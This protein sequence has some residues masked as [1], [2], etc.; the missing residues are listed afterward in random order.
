M[1]EVSDQPCDL[2]DRR[3]LGQVASR[4]QDHH[5]FVSVRNP[6]QGNDVEHRAPPGE[7]RCLQSQA[8]ARFLTVSKD[9]HEPGVSVC[10]VHLCGQQARSSIRLGSPLPN[11][12]AARHQHSSERSQALH[13][14]CD[15]DALHES[16]ASDRSRLL[17]IGEVMACPVLWVTR[18][19]SRDL[20][21]VA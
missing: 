18:N 12:A 9:A 6:R 14:V 21:A 4:L 5:G 1:I 10:F 15:G 20:G 11:Q 13:P 7:H 16:A 17:S 3:R 2:G 19:A 8:A